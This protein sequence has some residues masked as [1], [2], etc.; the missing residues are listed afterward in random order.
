MKTNF[1]N[2]SLSC[3]SSSESLCSLEESSRAGNGSVNDGVNRV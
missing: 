2:L 3:S 1:Y